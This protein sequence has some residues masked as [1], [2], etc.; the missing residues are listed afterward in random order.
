MQK[1]A[2][3]SFIGR[4]LCEVAVPGSEEGWQGETQEAGVVQ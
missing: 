1:D 4:V 2:V 3:H